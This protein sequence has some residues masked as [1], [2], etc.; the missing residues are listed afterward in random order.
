MKLTKEMI[1]MSLPIV[2]WLIKNIEQFGLFGRGLN[3]N[4]TFVCDRT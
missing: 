1:Y 2:L 3:H 4:E